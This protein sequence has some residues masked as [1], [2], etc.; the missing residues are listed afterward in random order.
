MPAYLASLFVICMA[1]HGELVMRRPAGP[2]LTRFYL[3]VSLGG[4]LGGAFVGLIAPNIFNTYVELPLLLVLIA[5]LYVILQ[6]VRR[7][8]RR[9][10]LLI[11]VVM[12]LG[13]LTLMGELLRS[14]LQDR[15]QSV[16]VQRNFYGV[17]SVQDDPS[18]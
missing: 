5:E 1:C 12:V 9:T 15:R 10:L 16:L 11:R 2:H 17:L 3:L 18:S 14:E 4:M 7:G 13:V 6:W 8:S